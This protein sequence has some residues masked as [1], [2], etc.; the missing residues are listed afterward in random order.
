MSPL[1]SKPSEPTGK[2]LLRNERAGANYDHYSLLRLV[3]DQF[4][5]GSLG[6]GDAHATIITGWKK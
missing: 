2:S 6:Q 4:G 3:E 5:L 1:P